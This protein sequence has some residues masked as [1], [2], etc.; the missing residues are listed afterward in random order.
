[1]P[2]GYRSPTRRA[3]LLYG[4]RQS[5]CTDCSFGRGVHAHYVGGQGAE[6][7]PACPMIMQISRP[8]GQLA[9]ALAD[10]GFKPSERAKGLAGL[11]P[12]LLR[13]SATG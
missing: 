7:V 13:V 8:W 9:V 4:R 11:G 12:P 5:P 6:C 3:W 1:M 2:L 10:R